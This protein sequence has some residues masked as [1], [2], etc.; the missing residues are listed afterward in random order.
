M[1][2]LKEQMQS[3]IKEKESKLNH[4]TWKTFD[5]IKGETYNHKDGFSCKLHYT[6][7]HRNP[8]AMSL[9]ISAGEKSNNVF[10]TFDENGFKVL[11][12]RCRHAYDT[13]KYID[14]PILPTYSYC[15][16]YLDEGNEKALASLNDFIEWNSKVEIITNWLNNEYV[17]SFNK[18][19]DAL[20]SEWKSLSKMKSE[21]DNYD[22]FQYQQW[23]NECI[24]N[25]VVKIDNHPFFDYDVNNDDELKSITIYETAVGVYTKYQTTYGRSR[26]EFI[27]NEV[28][29]KPMKGGKFEM[30][31]NNEVHGHVDHV[32]D[33]IF[34]KLQFTNFMKMVWNKNTAEVYSKVEDINE[35]IANLNLRYDVTNVPSEIGKYLYV[36]D[37]FKKEVKSIINNK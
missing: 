21:L 31:Y 28:R 29:I 4:G 10:F 11:N 20:I 3:D 12:E 7:H 5:E 36:N 26:N 6:G 9:T 37:E 34:T 24:K 17:P 18:R 30:E 32:N 35:M 33:G 27:R 16:I 19:F 25:G 1:N 2:N 8:N 23:Y 13:N 14:S 22:E 15:N